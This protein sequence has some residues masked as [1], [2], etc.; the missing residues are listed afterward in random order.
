MRSVLQVVFSGREATSSF[1]FRFI[2]KLFLSLA[3]ESMLLLMH[4]GLCLN[5]RNN[6]LVSLRSSWSDQC[7][8][9][10]I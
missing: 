4:L 8:Y 3:F 2:I 7:I 1:S 5:R 6:L 10:E 9:R